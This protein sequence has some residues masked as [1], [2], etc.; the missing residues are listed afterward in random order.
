ML[1]FC[2]TAVVMFVKKKKMGFDLNC[3]DV[4]TFSSSA[5]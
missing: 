1:K 4:E 2:F 5:C 3:A